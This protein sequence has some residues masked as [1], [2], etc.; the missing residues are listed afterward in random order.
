MSKKDN[1]WILFDEIVTFHRRIAIQDLPEEYH[2][3]SKEDLEKLFN[4]EDG[5]LNEE[6]W[7]LTPDSYSCTD[8]DETFIDVKEMSE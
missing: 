4:S 1:R 8:G 3:K 6:I 5:K 2:H 7:D